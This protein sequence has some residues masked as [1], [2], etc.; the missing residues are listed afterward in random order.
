[1]KRNI[2]EFSYH[3][4]KGIIFQGSSGWG[5]RFTMAGFTVKL[6]AELVGPDV[7][8]EEMQEMI[9]LLSESYYAKD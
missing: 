8:K 7:T 9:D 6:D 2:Q 3:G 4:V 5:G 1:M